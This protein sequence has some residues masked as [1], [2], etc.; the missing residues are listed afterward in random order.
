MNIK[1]ESITIKNFFSYGDVTVDLNNL[2]NVLVRGENKCVADNALSNGAGKSTIFNA[3]CFALIGETINGIS[4]GVENIFADKNN[5]SVTL[6]FYVDNT[7]FTI[8]RTKTPKADLKLFIDDVD[9]SGKGIRDTEKLL[10]DYLPDLTAELIGSIIILGQGLP[11]K[12]SNNKPA[13]R[14]EVLESLT[15]SDFMIQEI[16]D[17]LAARLDTVKDLIR[18]NN[19]KL[20]SNQSAM[21][22]NNSWIQSWKN[23]LASYN[24]STSVDTLT[25]EA[26]KLESVISQLNNEKAELYK[27]ASAPEVHSENYTNAKSLL[28]SY[29]NSLSTAKTALAEN[30][31]YVNIY[32]NELARLANIKD[33]CPTCGQKIPNV[34]KPDTSATV[35]ALNTATHN[36]ELINADI[37]K[38][39]NYINEVN[40]F[41]SAEDLELSNIKSK[42]FADMRAIDSQISTKTSELQSLNAELAKVREAEAAKARLQAQI[43]S[44]LANNLELEANIKTCTETD[45]ELNARATILRQLDTLAKREFRGVLLA[46]IIKQINAKVVAYSAYLFDNATVGLFLDGNNI[47]IMFNDKPY[48]NLSGGEKQKIDILIQLSLRSVLSELLNIHSNILCIDEI[49]D[50][51]DTTGCTRVMDLLASLADIESLFIISHHADELNIAYDTELVVQKGKNGVSTI[52]IV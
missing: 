25:I 4:S 48:E 11:D 44:A 7:K 18:D 14:K 51:L 17:K 9:K 40:A 13:K 33:V 39:N 35:Q 27:Q 37:T 34:V 3:I 26:T 16:K 15:K 29:T 38:L 6:T 36:I 47:S 23:E 2:G 49:F 5:C 32:K 22:T 41:I 28:E 42:A 50:N 45:T 46:N 30:N 21:T 12:F 1:F 10:G 31:S 52:K 43:D 19:A 8:I 20:V 24:I